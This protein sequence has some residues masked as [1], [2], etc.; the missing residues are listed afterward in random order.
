MYNGDNPLLK[1]SKVTDSNPIFSGGLIRSKSVK[2][3]LTIIL[4]D[5]DK[6]HQHELR[7]VEAA[8]GPGSHRWQGHRPP[9]EEGRAQD[10]H[11]RRQEA[12]VLPEETV[13]TFD[14]GFF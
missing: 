1:K 8:P 5:Q 12:S 9:Q 14:Q 6:S 4:T 2:V 11:H 7:K 13:G 10:R 3:Y